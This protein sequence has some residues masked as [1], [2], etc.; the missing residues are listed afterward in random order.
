MENNLKFNLHGVDYNINPENNKD[1]SN[2]Q[3]YISWF[4]GGGWE[5]NTFETFNYVKNPT[6]NAIDIGA[7]I[8]TTTIWLAKN[9]K[10]VL[11]IDADSVAVKALEA[12]LKTSECF[13]TQIL[14]KPIH[15]VN[16]K[17]IF[18]TNQYDPLYQS[19]GLGAST[20]QIKDGGFIDSD[21]TLETI[22]MDQLNQSF[23]FSE[24]SFVKVDIEGG[25]ELILE[26]LIKNAKKYNW[27]L[28]ISFHCDWWKDKNIDR[29]N[30]LFDDAIDI[31]IDNLTNK[32]HSWDVIDLI[33]SNPFA[34]LYIKYEN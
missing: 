23:P 25:E 24:V 30:G 17:V 12:N 31:R 21:Y 6:K 32:V 14:D 29:F 15:S 9:F 18:G 13:N 10:N 33:K 20:S 3:W 11:A 27:E 1:V 4:K 19:E 26:D 8:G 16:T 5:D 28:W 22:T 34:S 7:W 2:F